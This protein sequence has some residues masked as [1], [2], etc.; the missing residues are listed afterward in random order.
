MS[1]LFR[2]GANLSCA[3]LITTPI[4]FVLCVVIIFARERSYSRKTPL[5]GNFG[6]HLGLAVSLWDFI[7]HNSFSVK[8]YIIWIGCF[9]ILHFIMNFHY[10]SFYCGKTVFFVI[11]SHFFTFWLKVKGH[12]FVNFIL[13]WLKF[14]MYMPDY[15]LDLICS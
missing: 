3:C 1:I 5:F 12:N 8:W 10:L 15:D 9:F 4:Y 7:W 2:F 6:G 13:I 11:F 14:G